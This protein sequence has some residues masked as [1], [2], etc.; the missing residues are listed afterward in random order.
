MYNFYC[1]MYVQSLMFH[2]FNFGAPGSNPGHLE[3]V[4]MHLE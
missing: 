1:V 3:G 4:W 2:I